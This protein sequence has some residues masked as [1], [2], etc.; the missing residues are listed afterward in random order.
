MLARVEM[1]VGFAV[2]IFFLI[3]VSELV[4]WAVIVEGLRWI[5]RW[6]RRWQ[7][8]VTGWVEPREYREWMR[9]RVR[10]ARVLPFVRRGE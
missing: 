8:D 4:C 7:S 3:G 6:R 1:Y 5:C 10:G 9:K 2:A